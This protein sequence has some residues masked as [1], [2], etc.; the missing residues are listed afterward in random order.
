[1]RIAGPGRYAPFALC[2]GLLATSAAL[3][4]VWPWAWAWTASFGALSAL[5]VC[6][7]LQRRL[8]ILRNY[9]VIGHCP[10]G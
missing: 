6:D 10:T 1:M 3:V 4:P 9:P 8:S 2:L 7:L 5:G